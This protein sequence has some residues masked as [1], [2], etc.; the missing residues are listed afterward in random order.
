VTICFGQVDALR[1]CAPPIAEGNNFC[2]TREG[3]FIFQ[4][5]VCSLLMRGGR[6]II[7]ESQSGVDHTTLSAL[8]LDFIGTLLHQR[9]LFVLHASALLVGGGAVAF[10]GKSGLGKSTL[11]LTL[12]LRGCPV[13]SDDII[14]VD[15]AGDFPRVIPA[16]PEL[17]VWPETLTALSNDPSSFDR[18]RPASEKRIV[19]TSELFVQHP[20]P[21][22]RIYLLT[23]GEITR[24]ESLAPREATFALVEHSYRP[25]LSEGSSPAIHLFQCAQLAR[26]IPVRC[27]K[28]HRTPDSI[29]T[30]AQLVEADA[31]GTFS[32]ASPG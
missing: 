32:Q 17:N 19:P 15:L 26:I 12:Y 8:I 29:D 3:A 23:E 30:L 18:V 6:E 16:Y 24:I 21:L 10:M 20:L 13:I 9:G 1:D 2:I 4:E 5:G 11:A 25:E 31:R 22:R 14:S 28:I 7:I 27:V